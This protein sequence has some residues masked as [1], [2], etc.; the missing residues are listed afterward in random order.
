MQR[1]RFDADNVVVLPDR[2]PLACHGSDSPL[3]S[4]LGLL[5]SLQN[6]LLVD[7]EDLLV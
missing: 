6:K 4:G 2:R 5:L 1:A 7:L 3:L